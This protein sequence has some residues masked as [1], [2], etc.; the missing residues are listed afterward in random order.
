MRNEPYKSSATKPTD[1]EEPKRKKRKLPGVHSETPSAAGRQTS[2]A[3]EEK[4]WS[5]PVKQRLRRR[6]ESKATNEPSSGTTPT[7]LREPKRKKQKLL[8]VYSD[9]SAAADTG[10]KICSLKSCGKAINIYE[11][12]LVEVKVGINQTSLEFLSEC[13]VRW[14]EVSGEAQFHSDC[15]TGLEKEAR[16]R[17]RRMNGMSKEEKALVREAAETAEWHDSRVNFDPS[18]GRIA[19]FLTTSGYCIAFTGAGI[20]TSAGIGDYRGKDGKWTKMDRALAQGEEKAVEEDEDEEDGVAY[21]KLRP[22]Y[23]HEALAKLMEMGLVKHV[24]SQNGDGLHGL[25]GIPPENLSELHGNVFLEICEKCGHRYLRPY[26][27]LDD[28]ASQ[29]YEEMEELGESSVAKPKHAKQCEL[30]G[31]NHRTGRRCEQA[32]CGGFLKDSIIN[33]GDNLEEDVLVT[34]ESHARKADLCLCLGTTLQVTPACKLVEM[35][36]K[37]LRLVIVNR[38]TTPLDHLALQPLPP[39]EDRFTVGV[40]VLGDVDHVMQAVMKSLM[41]GYKRHA[42]E[43]DMKERMKEYDCLRKI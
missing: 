25:S 36:Q 40:R 14:H 6:N 28:V 34:A 11:D 24:I 43:F 27:V 21:E 33:F 30:C 18:T 23:T 1:L 10:A 4:S 19:A 37:P 35:C 7:N 5:L 41:T 17:G 13:V 38:Q 32:G 15:W 8:K 3:M 2:G 9:T 29:Y 12:T 22:T 16:A 31:L 20:S 42:W 26:Y 39:P